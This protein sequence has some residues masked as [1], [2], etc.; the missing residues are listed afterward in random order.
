MN[1]LS[2]FP[3]IL[4]YAIVF[5][6]VFSFTGCENTPEDV[7]NDFYIDNLTI[8]NYP[9]VDGSTSTEPLQIIIAS[10]LLG[11]DY[12]W[13]YMSFWWKYPYRVLPSVE[14]NTEAARYITERIFNTGT[15]T[16]F[17][18][19][20][21]GYRDLILVARTASPDELHLADSLNVELREV[22]V[23]LDA[24]IF[25]VNKNNPVINLSTKQIQDVYTGK[26]TNW[27]AVGGPETDIHPYLRERNSGS[28]ELME[29]MV[30]K[31]LKMI[32]APDMIMYGMIG[33][34]NQIE[35]DREGL[36][37]SVNYYTEY[38]IRSDSVKRIAVDGVYPDYN[39]LRTRE[40]NYTAE[41]YA[42]IR[43]NL[44][45]N[46]EAYKL[47]ELLAEPSGQQVIKESGYI[48]YY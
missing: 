42:V 16:A 1:A 40:Y 41:V 46:S 24:F 17:E 9:K 8:D 25:L 15:H 6:I 36:G 28:Q 33:M 29:A 11:V 3:R 34:I 45:I 35:Y 19:L 39:A 43:E 7:I 14:S 27:N 38:M 32:D 20:I 5:I 37:Y 48:P 31:D 21:L 23:A 30:M 26:I 13:A 47:F 10:K 12:T 2:F 22:P 18:N 4:A 44:D